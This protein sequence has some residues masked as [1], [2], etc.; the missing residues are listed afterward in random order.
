VPI[1]FPNCNPGVWASANPHSSAMGPI[2]RCVVSGSAWARLTR[3]LTGHRC[4]VVPVTCP[5]RRAKVLGERPAVRAMLS[6][7]CGSSSDCLVRI[8]LH[9]RPP[10]IAR[11]SGEGDGEARSPTCSSA[12]IAWRSA[13][14]RSRLK[15][16]GML[17]S[18]LLPGRHR[19]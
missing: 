8:P 15:V 17:G 19:P 7:V 5:N 3:S 18:N 11:R 2:D 4:G 6:T 10:P 9:P 16:G 1:T 13:K 14:G 12:E